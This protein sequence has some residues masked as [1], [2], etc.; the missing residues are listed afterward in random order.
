VI[1]IDRVVG[2][3]IT[4][5]RLETDGLPGS[6]R[7][8]ALIRAGNALKAIATSEPQTPSAWLKAVTELPT[9]RAK[10]DYR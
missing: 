5:A 3:I 9:E 10:R 2:R 7:T 4:R 1:T 6:M 8:E